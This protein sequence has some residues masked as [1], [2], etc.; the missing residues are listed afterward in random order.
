MKTKL[1]LSYICQNDE[2][3]KMLNISCNHLQLQASVPW[4]VL[5]CPC[6][7]QCKYVDPC[8]LSHLWNFLDDIDFHLHFDPDPWLKPQCQANTFIM[9]ELSFLPS[10]TTN[11]LYQAQWCHSLYL[12]ATTMAD[13]CTTTNGLSI[14]A[15]A[16]TGQAWSW[17]SNFHFPQQSQPS[18]PI[19]N[20]WTQLLCLWYC[21]GSSLKLNTPLGQ[22]YCRCITQ[23]WDTIIDPNTINIYI[24]NQG[25]VH[26]YECQGCSKKQYCHLCSHTTIFSQLDVSL[27]LVNSRQAPS[28]SP[29]L[30]S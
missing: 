26:I 20:T 5:S 1:V 7:Q 27:S 15:W 25:H 8:Y 29:A 3:G 30:P 6:Y 12:G 14:C 23:T 19:W 9:D 10:I 2:V 28:S 16:L 17:S 18:K 24:W 11:E 21:G 13:I 4:P 22:W